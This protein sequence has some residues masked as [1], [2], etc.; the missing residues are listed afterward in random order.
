MLALQ[1]RPEDCRRLHPREI[2][3][4]APDCRSKHPGNTL[5][6][7]LW[8]QHALLRITHVPHREQ[9]HR[10]RPLHG[11]HGE[12]GDCLRLHRRRRKSRTKPIPRFLSH[13]S[14]HRRAARTVQAQIAGCK[15]RA[16]RGRN[17]GLRLCRRR[18]VCRRAGRH[19]HFGTGHLPEIRS[20]EPGRHHGTAAGSARRTARRSGHRTP[21]QIGTDRPLAGTLR[22]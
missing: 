18:L 20:H 12:Q 8:A 16:M 14:R 19:F 11:H 22:P 13:H 10:T 4:K 9:S 7:R 6:I 5:R 15:D 1:P 21:Y 17:L 2:R 3:Q